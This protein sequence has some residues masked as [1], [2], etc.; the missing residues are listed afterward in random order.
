MEVDSPRKYPLSREYPNR[1]IYCCYCNCIYNRG[2]ID[3]ENEMCIVQFTDNENKWKMKASKEPE[4]IP[5]KYPTQVL[6]GSTPGPSFHLSPTLPFMRDDNA[7]Y[8]ILNSHPLHTGRKTRF[9]GQLGY[10]TFTGHQSEPC[11][12]WRSWKKRSGR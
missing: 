6:D 9:R 10:F 4:G 8:K 3:I 12:S 2:A 7:E 11:S 5:T 1:A